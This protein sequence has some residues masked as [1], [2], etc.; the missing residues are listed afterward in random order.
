LNV[1]PQRNFTLQPYGEYAWQATEELR[2]RFGLRY[3]DVT[4]DLDA[5]VVQNFLSGTPGKVFRA[6][7]TVRYCA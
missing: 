5:S 1:I 4:R 7:N 6:A 3:R 2:V